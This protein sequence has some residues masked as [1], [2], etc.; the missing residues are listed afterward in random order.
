MKEARLKATEE[1]AI[2][3]YSWFDTESKTFKEM[4][5]TGDNLPRVRWI[6]KQAVDAKSA[7]IPNL[8]YQDVAKVKNTEVLRIFL[9][10][11]PKTQALL[12]LFN[13]FSLMRKQKLLVWFAYPVTLSI[14]EEILLVC[15]LDVRCITA[16]TSA[17]AR[18]KIIGDFNDPKI[19]F[20]GI[21]GA[22]GVS[23]TG[24]N[25]QHD[26]S[27]CVLFEGTNTVEEERQIIGRL[28]RM[29][30]VL[31]VYAYTLTVTDTAD[32]RR[33]Q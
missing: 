9:Q 26:S 2:D 13:T 30:Q 12:A 32:T 6:L 7:E 31:Q 10:F 29:G 15:G 1:D 18:K 19:R 27:A 20:A 33:I 16:D 3:R 28:Y 17:V 8:P 11:S 24:Y 4:P 21:L 22:Q 14:V 23:G 5:T 25:F